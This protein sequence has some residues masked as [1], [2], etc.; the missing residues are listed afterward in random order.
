MINNT[1]PYA[2]VAMKALTNMMT[3]MLASIATTPSNV[4][5]HVSVAGA[6]AKVQKRKMPKASL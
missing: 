3:T 5:V 2:A 4:I 6:A 1:W